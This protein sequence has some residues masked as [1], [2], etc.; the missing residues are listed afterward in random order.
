MH[1]ED[2]RLFQ[3]FKTKYCLCIQ[4]WNC[5]LEMIAEQYAEQ[6]QIVPNQTISQ[7][8]NFYFYT[9]EDIGETLF[10]MRQIE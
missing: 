7:K 2:R 1:V 4:K 10:I 3:K 5:E 8:F 9:F 6:C